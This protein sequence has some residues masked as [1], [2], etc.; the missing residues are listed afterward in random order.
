[1][2]RELKRD[3]LKAMAK[4]QTYYN[5]KGVKVSREDCQSLVT[6]CGLYEREGEI[7]EPWKEKITSTPIAE[8]LIKYR[9]W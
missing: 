6:L 4:E 3:I 8:V 2:Y 9:M 7:S 5:L 1:M